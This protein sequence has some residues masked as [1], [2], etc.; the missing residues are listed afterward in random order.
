MRTPISFGVVGP[1][2]WGSRVAQ[3]MG[4]LPGTELRWICD[5][6]TA[7][8]RA[9]RAP[10]AGVRYSDDL[11]ILLDDESLD[12][13]VIASPTGSHY[14]LAKLALEADKHVLVQSPIAE[15]SKEA[16]E[17]VREAG[18]RGC[19]LMA[20]GLTTFQPALHS[21]KKLLH[22]GVLGDAFYAYGNRQTF[23]LQPVDDPLWSFGGDVVSALLYLFDDQPVEVAARGEAYVRNNVADVVFGYL[24]FATGISAHLHLSAL[25]PQELCRLTV[26][27][28]R[29]MAVIDDLEPER[30]LTIHQKAIAEV[31]AHAQP[32]LAG[33]GD[34]VSPFV[35][36]DD[37]LRWEC[38]KFAS[39]VRSPFARPTAAP[40]A[41][42]V[43][44]LE[45]LQRSL[46][47]GGAAEALI[48]QVSAPV[49]RLSLAVALPDAL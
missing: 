39:A 44:I 26:V 18:K 29:A 16:W 2:D 34:I 19:V 11:S 45:S 21:L 6:S 48:A 22:D 49:E 25:D 31:Q 7:A 23:G 41:A 17:L 3:A 4:V 28:S 9:G 37:P 12:A 38:E 20:G 47:N 5:G 43:E 35:T 14:E 8:Q 30:K 40:A 1:N 42:T 24:K 13:L 33:A 36:R 32:T 15:S 10:L 46:D 27:G